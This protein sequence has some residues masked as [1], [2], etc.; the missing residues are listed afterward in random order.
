[1]AKTILEILDTI[2][3]VFLVAGAGFALSKLVLDRM[4]PSAARE[5]V[6]ATGGIPGATRRFLHV[7]AFHVAGPAYVFTALRTSSVSIDALGTP[8]VVAAVLYVA[9]TVVA[10]AVAGVARWDAGGRKAAV[11]ALAS[12]NCGNYGLPIMMFAFGQDGLVIGTVFMITHVLIH[13][14]LGLSIASWS[15]DHPLVRRLGSALR[16]P[17][18]YAIGLALLLR[19]VDAPIPEAIERALGLVGQMWMPLM[20]ILL[21]IELANVRVSHVWR[22]SAALA[23]IKLFAPP[24]IAFGLSAALGLEGIPRA[25][26][27]LQASMPTAVNG[28]LVARQFDVRPDLVASTLM[29]STIGSILTISVLLGFLA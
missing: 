10:F 16:F 14:T 5:G 6:P 27:I 1:M 25:V 23:G 18:V 15:G 12:K 9:M 28:L 8:A 17:Y 29:L 11:L 24:L 19:A 26:L 21:G 22:A 13:M 7:L 3:P 20:L 2:L 4:G